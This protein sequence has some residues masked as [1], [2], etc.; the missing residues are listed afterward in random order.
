MLVEVRPQP[1][2]ALEVD[3]A[4][5]VPGIHE[6][7]AA[8]LNRSRRDV[9]GLDEREE[10]LCLDELRIIDDVD[11]IAPGGDADADPGPGARTLERGEPRL[12]VCDYRQLT[13]RTCWP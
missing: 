1:L 8:P 11:V 5:I 3:Q 10:P 13:W 2:V 7:A 4:A 6:V 12:E 9:S